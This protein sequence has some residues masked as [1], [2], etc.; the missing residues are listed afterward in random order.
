MKEK[1]KALSKNV[2]L[3]GLVVSFTLNPQV[4]AVEHSTAPPPETEKLVTWVRNAFFTANN[5]HSL[6]ELISQSL[7]RSDV[8]ALKTY[9]GN[10]SFP[11]TVAMKDR[12]MIGDVE[13]R[14]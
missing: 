14:V 1:L 13:L 9:F 8:E 5:T 4:R 3:L 7:V 2:L 10:S 12:L 6:I 11:L